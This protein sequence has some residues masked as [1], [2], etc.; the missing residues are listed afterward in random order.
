M[1]S[2]EAKLAE[3]LETPP[4]GILVLDPSGRI[5]VFNEE[6]AAMWDVSVDAL[7]SQGYKGFLRLALSRLKDSRAFLAELRRLSA[8]PAAATN[9]VV[10]LKDGRVFECRSEPRLAEGAPCGRVF[11]FRDITLRTKMETSPNEADEEMH[12]FDLLMENLPEHIYFKDAQG[13]FTRVNRAQARLFG[14]REPAE[15]VGKSDFDFFTP[16]HSQPAYEDE[17]ALIQE[18]LP[19][20]S[21]EEKETWPDGRE[22]WALTTKLPL[23][24]PQGR[25]VGTFGISRDITDRKRAEQELQA[26]KKAAEAANRAKGEFLANMSH[27][28]RTPLNGVIGMT[29]LLLDMDLT[30]EQRECADM[31]RKSGEALLTLLNDILDFSKIEAGKLAIESA[32]FDLRVLIEEVMEMLEP[33]AEDK[34]IDLIL[35]YPP[36]APRYVVGDGSRIRQV[37]TNLVGNAVKFTQRGHVLV[38]VDC[39]TKDA[40]RIVMRVRVTDTGIGIPPEKV[41][42]LFQKFSQVGGSDARRYGGSGLGLAISKQLVEL[43]GGMIGV[44][45]L[46]GKGSTFWFTLPLALDALPQVTPL[47]SEDLAGLRVL[48][49][50]DNEVNRR[51]IHD[52]IKSWGMRN[53]GCATAAEALEAIR[54]AHASGDPY[55]FV[56]ADFRISV[57]DGATLASVIKDDPALKDTV[58]VMLTSVGRWREAKGLEG[59]SVDACLARPVRQSQLF[60]TLASAWLK[61]RSTCRSVTPQAEPRESAP[62]ITWK[63]RFDGSGLRVLVAEDNIVNQKVAVRM[64]ERMGIR[65]DMA[66][67]GREAVHM[68]RLL[69]YDVIFMDCQM[70]DMDGYAATRVIRRAE[71]PDQHVVI[72]AMT[73]EALDG[74]REQCIACGMDDF[75]A[76]PVKIGALVDA[77]RKWGTRERNGAGL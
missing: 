77:L 42:L 50:D 75:V 51:V 65:A 26:A 34:G 40:D 21:K 36:G 47:S 38:G 6:L 59:Q 25:I 48:I 4:E 8:E 29:G 22:T 32:A 39:E 66:G 15:L 64:L 18:R 56:V 71:K 44:N 62:R 5:D 60:N 35:E 30:P 27:E 70:P 14:L 9:D 12:L 10:R 57:M 20:I 43:M 24:D 72:I 76:K 49:V 63:D 69:S 19:M 16:E 55:Q 7:T 28:I 17:Q 58:V 67:D 37:V 53:G 73:A 74:S 61:K 13:R 23:R 11:T 41:G 46:P 68:E 31:A 2:S 1:P 54:A 3:I 33:K 52:Q 45:S